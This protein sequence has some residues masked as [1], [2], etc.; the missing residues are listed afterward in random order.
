M[1]SHATFKGHPIHPMLVTIPIGLWVTSLVCDIIYA[2]TRTVFWYDMAWW[3]MAFGLVGALMAAIPGLIDYNTTIRKS[4]R[5]YPTARLHMII[6]LSVVAA[7]AIN[8]WLRAD[9]NAAGGTMMAVAIGL[10]VLTL[11]AL[12]VSGYLGG[13]LVYHYGIGLTRE[14]LRVSMLETEKEEAELPRR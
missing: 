9:Y 2:T 4:E 8:L 3:S 10:S 6:N 7:F 1:K 5:A 12:S 13:H 11:G 14:D